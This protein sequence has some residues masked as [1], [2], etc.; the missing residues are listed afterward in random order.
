[1]P[2]QKDSLEMVELRQN[3]YDFKQESRK[4]TKNGIG[5]IVLSLA[6]AAFAILCVVTNL[7]IVISIGFFV[8]AFVGLCRG[9]YSINK[10]AKCKGMISEITEEIEKIS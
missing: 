6:S 2:I 4:A 9:I 10:A 7:G 8:F 1:M 3:L 5:F